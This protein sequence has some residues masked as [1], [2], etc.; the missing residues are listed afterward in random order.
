MSSTIKVEVDVIKPARPSVGDQQV[1]K[2]V[3]F[4]IANVL[5][6]AIA[7]GIFYLLG[8][9]ISEG[10]GFDHAMGGVQRFFSSHMGV[11]ALAASTPFFA[12]LLVGQY[13]MRKA[14][15]RRARQE[16]EQRR[17][18]VALDLAAEQAARDARRAVK[19]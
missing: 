18:Q 2:L 1:K 7:A 11:A 12:S 3:W 13:E 4:I 19:H 8:F 5:S 14:R 10:R 17:S 9:G 16:A 6:F 15:A